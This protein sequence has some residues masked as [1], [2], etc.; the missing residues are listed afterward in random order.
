M[1]KPEEAAVEEMER[2]AQIL[3]IWDLEAI[4]SGN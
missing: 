3:H 2:G 1:I 4:G